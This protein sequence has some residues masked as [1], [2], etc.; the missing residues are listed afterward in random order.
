L[1]GN[2]SQFFTGGLCLSAI[3]LILACFLVV[4]VHAI[5]QWLQP[6]SER[7]AA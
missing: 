3:A 2:W 6:V 4:L 5:S 7:P 1:T